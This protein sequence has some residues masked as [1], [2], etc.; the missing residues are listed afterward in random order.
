M[1]G[2]RRQRGMEIAVQVKISERTGQ[3]RDSTD[4]S[5]T[6]G[7]LGRSGSVDPIVFG[8]PL[9]LAPR[10]FACTVLCRHR[11]TVPPPRR[12]PIYPPLFTKTAL[13]LQLPHAKN[14]YLGQTDKCSRV[15]TWYLLYPVPSAAAPEPFPS[16]HPSSPC[17]CAPPRPSACWSQPRQPET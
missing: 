4:P 9:A 2:R 15:G 14:H 5:T 8:G 11:C 17:G 3:A 1:S 16:S 6:K 7:S 13:I 10:S 12:T